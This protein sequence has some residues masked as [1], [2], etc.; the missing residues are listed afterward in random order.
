MAF[1]KTPRFIAGA[2]CPRCSTMDKVRVYNEDGKDYRECVECGFKQEQ[3][4]QPQYREPETRVNTSEEDRK[5]Q[6]QVVKI[7]PM[8]DDH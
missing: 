5:A 2:I 1:S 7:L 4:I 8:G 3:H 6:E